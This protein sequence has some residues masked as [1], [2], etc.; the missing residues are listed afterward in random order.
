MHPLIEHA[1]TKFHNVLKKSV[2]NLLTVVEAS[3]LASC[4]TA[5]SEERE[6]REVEMA[7]RS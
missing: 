2:V 6:V 1:Q 7:G 3:D 5:T 4:S